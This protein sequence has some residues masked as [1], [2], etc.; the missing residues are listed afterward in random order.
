VALTTESAGAL[1]PG[2]P[3][4]TTMNTKH[5]RVLRAFYFNGKPTV[6]GEPV[7][8][9]AVFALEM[10]AAKKLE[11]IDKPARAIET[12]KTDGKSD[13]GKGGKDAG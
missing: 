2:A 10:A 12:A 6:V 11:L 5:G 7:E 1:I 4:E 3:L 8:L 9:P 13:K